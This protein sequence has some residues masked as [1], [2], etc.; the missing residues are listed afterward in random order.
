MFLICMREL[1]PEMKS[2]T[3]RCA[4]QELSLFMLLPVLCAQAQY[5][6][7]LKAWHHD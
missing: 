6:C 2:M 7:E 1:L 5:D 4:A 3:T